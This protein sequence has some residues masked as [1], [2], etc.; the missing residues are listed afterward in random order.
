MPDL[1]PGTFLTA[2]NRSND[3]LIDRAKQASGASYTGIRSI[4]AQ[5]FAVQEDQG[6]FVMDRSLE[7]LVSSDAAIIAVR[8]RLL[9]AAK[10]L[11]DGAEPPEAADGDLYR[12]RSL[13]V[14][15]PRDVP[16]GVGGQQMMIARV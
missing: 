3:Y 12:I 16:I 9:D 7:H 5:D 4:S 6:G 8:K 1:I 13:D 14:V 2:E 15:L 10:A 11:G